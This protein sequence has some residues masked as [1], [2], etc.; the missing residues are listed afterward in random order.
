[1]SEKYSDTVDSLLDLPVN[2]LD[3]SAGGSPVVISSR[4]R[5]ARNLREFNFPPAISADDAQTVSKVLMQAL[6]HSKI[7]GPRSRKFF[8]E[9]LDDLD[10]EILFERHLVSR[11]LLSN[12]KHPA[13]YVSG[14]ESLSA[15]VNEE[16]H[17]RMQVILPGLQLPRAWQEINALDDQ[18]SCELDFA[19]DGL[20]GY[21]TSC[22]SNLGT[23]LRVSVMLHLPALTMEN[24]IKPLE[25]ALSKRGLTVR[26]MF[27]EGSENLGNFYQISNQ[28]TLGESEMQII[29][30]L[31]RV[32]DEVVSHEESSR[33]RL[34][35]QDRNRL[36]DFVGRS[37][38]LLRHSYMLSSQEAF[39]S[40]SGIRLGVDMH[41]FNT[42]N[43]RVVNDL[44][45]AISPAHLQKRF[46][47]VLNGQERD[48]FRA[49]TVRAQL[50]INGSM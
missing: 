2:F 6:E 7:A 11:E 38:G 29:E 32:I 22:P 44:F 34:L 45:M 47:R 37:F 25:R 50:K 18:L 27:G 15:M 19:Y 41:M 33:N 10:R 31:S 39:N 14:D 48:A 36:L 20:L 23:G 30:R 49:E 1:M 42:L 8:I 35:E 16:D 46:G 9:E 12:S 4:I 24:N 40:L 21:L 26:G 28:S 13:V 17:L 43:R 5:L 3:D